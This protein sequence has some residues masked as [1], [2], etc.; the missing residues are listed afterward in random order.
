MVTVER[1]L[2]WLQQL[3]VT[4]TVNGCRQLYKFIDCITYHFM[5]ETGAGNSC[6]DDSARSDT[7]TTVKNTTLLSKDHLFYNFMV[8]TLDA[9][10]KCQVIDDPQ[11][12]SKLHCEW[13]KTFE[14][15]YHPGNRCVYKHTT[16]RLWQRITI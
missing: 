1:K 14:T 6:F 12:L 11:T 13:Y 9:G 15:T 7:N 2:Q 8:D 5:T 16:N 4:V 3:L 10:N